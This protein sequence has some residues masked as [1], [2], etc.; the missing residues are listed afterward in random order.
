[1]D[2]G[3]PEVQHPNSGYAY[4]IEVP[5]TASYS[6][7]HQPNQPQNVYQRQRSDETLPGTPDAVPTNAASEIPDAASMPSGEA[8][9]SNGYPENRT[10]GFV[11]PEQR[12]N[13]QQFG[14]GVP[15]YYSGYPYGDMPYGRRHLWG[16]RR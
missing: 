6:N 11:P 8:A 9:S 12:P 7:Y 2:A 16:S 3:R 10:G 4:P 13:G 5:P 15:P 14:G 1:M